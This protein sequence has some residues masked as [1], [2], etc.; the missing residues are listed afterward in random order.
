MIVDISTMLTCSIDEAVSH[1]KTPRLLEFVASPL[2][3][4]VPVRPPVFPEVWS[5][6]EYSV[7]LRLFGVVPF[8][9]QAIVIA[10]PRHDRRRGHEANPFFSVA[11]CCYPFKL[12]PSV[13]VRFRL[14]PLFPIRPS[15]A[16]VPGTGIPNGNKRFR[17]NTDTNGEKQ[18][19]TDPPRSATNAVACAPINSRIQSCGQQE[20]SLQPRS[21]SIRIDFYPLLSVQA[22]TVCFPPFPSVSAV[23][24]PPIARA[25][26]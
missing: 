7:A 26:P 3:R 10:R 13:S 2:V 5:T 22:G 6:G 14:F 18:I 25:N 17:H 1:L 21:R 9:T 16:R 12:E 15:R 8:G 4:F 19:T 20:S 24:H 11:I 23:S